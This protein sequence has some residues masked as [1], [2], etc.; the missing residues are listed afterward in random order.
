MIT[1][2]IPCFN[3]R[4]YVGEA[5]RSAV[6]Q[7]GTSVIV[8]DDGSTDGSG[9]VA[10]R[11]PHVQVIRQPNAGVAAARNA[12]LRAASGEFVLFLDSDDRLK[13]HA[14]ARLRAALERHPAAVLAYGGHTLIDA[15][16]APLAGTPAPRAPGSAFDALLQSNYIVVP[17]SVLY[18]RLLL[19]GVGGFAAGFDAVADYELYLRLTRLYDVV[20]IDDVVIEYRRHSK[21]LSAN[22]RR[23]L[24]ETLQVHRWHGQRAPGAS[25]RSAY[26]KGRRFWSDFYGDQIMDRAR[27]AWR[28][29]ER[30]DALT[31][32]AC[33]AR[34]A[35]RVLLSHLV[36]AMLV[37]ARGQRTAYNANR[38]SP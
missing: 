30:R 2:I 5:V 8:V 37:R 3:Q 34:L 14:V 23:M 22:P 25:S 11:Y 31:D 15:S 27:Q 4:A 12:G 13:E 33:V 16:G 29:R 21:S 9:E 32:I 7:P 28:R 24:A 26:R 6:A 20:G 18:R 17:G 10:A 38:L 1:I 35:P 19:V 36:R